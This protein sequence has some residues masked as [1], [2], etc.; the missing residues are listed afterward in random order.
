MTTAKPHKYT[1]I[2]A[3]ED[4]ERQIN[5]ATGN[6]ASR[7]RATGLLGEEAQSANGGAW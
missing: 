7:L 1:M 4:E 2:D 3:S 6:T 5:A